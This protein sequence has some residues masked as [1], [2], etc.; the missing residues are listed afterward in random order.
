MKALLFVLL[1]VG[2]ALAI[3]LTAFYVTRA[4]DA[5][6]RFRGKLPGGARIF[7][8]LGAALLIVGI[9]ALVLHSSSDRIPSGAGTYTVK[10][11][12]NLQDGRVIF[13]ETCSSC[14]TLAAAQAR[15]VYGPNLDTQ[16]AAGGA[17]PKTIAARVQSAIKLGGATG[18]QMPANL[19]EGA[20]A[21]SVSDYVAAVAGK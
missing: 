11:S 7:V 21:K 6:P 10:A 1:W 20:D 2:V 19:L 8:S 16:L 5:A 3:F 15:G 4:K 13:R 12:T 9:P 18:K 17:D 14:H